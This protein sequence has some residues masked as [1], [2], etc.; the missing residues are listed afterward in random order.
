M[1]EVGALWRFILRRKG[2]SATL[3]GLF[4]ALP[5]ALVAWRAS[6]SQDTQ[7]EA[8]EI[9]GALI[10]PIILSGMLPFLTLLV[11]LP[12][13]VEPF[14]RGTATYLLSR[15]LP[16]WKVVLGFYLGGISAMAIPLA[17]GA[18]APAAILWP[19]TP[20]TLSLTKKVL[21]LTSVALLGALPYGALTLLLGTA[22][23]KPLLWS[24]ALVVGWGSVAGS[25]T[26]PLRATSPHRYLHSL[27]RKWCD[28]PNTWEGL[29]K[30]FS[31]PDLTPPG[32]ILSLTVILGSSAVF[33]FFAWKGIQRR[34]II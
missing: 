25:I 11:M 17:I 9:Y 20:D 27:L 8:G 34:D 29:G 28:V 31:I 26:G 16:R 32:T 13:T 12:L 10:G 2:L 1:N 5:I 15:P 6:L 21:G 23:R 7:L 4:L 24:L 3:N 14:E 22:I 19:S 33:L 18:L 30:T